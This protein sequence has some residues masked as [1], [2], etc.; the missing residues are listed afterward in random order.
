MARRCDTVQ[1]V[2]GT[3]AVHKI[4]Y[5]QGEDF[6][7]GAESD[8]LS[9]FMLRLLASHAELKSCVFSDLIQSGPS[10]QRLVRTIQCLLREL[11]DFDGEEDCHVKSD[12]P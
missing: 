11:S 8:L 1:Y 9:E 3:D 5:Q 10:G 2:E 6:L 4:P 7:A 12:L